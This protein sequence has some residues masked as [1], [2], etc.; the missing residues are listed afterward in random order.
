MHYKLSNVQSRVVDII[1]FYLFTCLLILFLLIY[2]YNYRLQVSKTSTQFYGD[3]ASQV[4][5]PTL[6]NSLPLHV[7]HCNTLQSFKSTLKTYLFLNDL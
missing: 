7:R 3:R 2:K 1:C 4:A 6:W 5:A